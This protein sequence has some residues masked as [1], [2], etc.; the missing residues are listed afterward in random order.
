MTNVSLIPHHQYEIFFPC[1]NE[2]YEIVMTHKAHFLVISVT[3]CQAALISFLK[4]S[5]VYAE[6]TAH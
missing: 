6:L 3:H 4:T 5:E 2:K 1:H